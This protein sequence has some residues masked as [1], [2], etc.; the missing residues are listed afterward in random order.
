M[1]LV[2]AEVHP[3]AGGNGRTSRFSRWLDMRS[4]QTAF[5]AL[6]QSN[7]LEQPA[8]AR[9]SFDDSLIARTG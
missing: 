7:A 5:A 4:K 3:F 8:A 1:P 9:L 6:K 2:V